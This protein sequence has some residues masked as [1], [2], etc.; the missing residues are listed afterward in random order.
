MARTCCSENSGQAAAQILSLWETRGHLVI[1][2]SERWK[3]AGMSVLGKTRD[4]TFRW[5]LTTDLAVGRA[6]DT[7]RVVG[8]GHARQAHKII[9]G[10]E[11]DLLMLGVGSLI[12]WRRVYLARWRHE[13]A[14]ASNH[15]PAPGWVT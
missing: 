10:I 15:G 13:G 11:A 3:L 2:D 1:L 5:L 12:P 8:A 6:E 14:Y 9:A 7:F 4:E